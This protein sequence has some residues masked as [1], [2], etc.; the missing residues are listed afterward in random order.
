MQVSACNAVGRVALPQVP[1]HGSPMDVRQS[2][3]AR[4]ARGAL[5]VRPAAWL[6]RPPVSR[7]DGAGSVL[8]DPSVSLFALR[9]APPPPCVERGGGCLSLCLSALQRSA[10]RRSLSGWGWGRW[11]SPSTATSGVL[12][13]SAPRSP[14]RGSEW[15]I[16]GWLV[17]LA[18]LALGVPQVPRPW[19]S[20][21]VRRTR[22]D[23]LA[24]RRT[25][26]H[27]RSPMGGG[28][29]VPPL[30]LV[31][32]SGASSPRGALCWGSHAGQR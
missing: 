3:T 9:V 23:G 31:S 27:G 5:G 4:R 26:P 24:A 7:W 20:L 15:G 6:H 32:A 1:R 30:F 18:M 17:H 10:S 21:D 2:Q 11:T 8:A 13:Y 12:G 25:A 16:T 29:P 19:R 28:P 14:V 22:C